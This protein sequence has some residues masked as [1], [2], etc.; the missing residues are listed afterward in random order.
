MLSTHQFSCLDVKLFF[1]KG[2][3]GSRQNAK[4]PK[5][6]GR[7]DKKTNWLMDKVTAGP[8]GKGLFDKRDKM[9]NGPNVKRLIARGR[10]GKGQN[11]RGQGGHTL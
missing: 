9:G 6:T 5:S 2:L 11:G 8:N 4:R 3:T 10:I 7:I 1:V